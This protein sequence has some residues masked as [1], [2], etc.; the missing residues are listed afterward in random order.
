VFHSGAGY[1][2][3]DAKGGPKGG[4]D[5]YPGGYGPPGGEGGANAGTPAHG[6]TTHSAPD[7]HCYYYNARTGTSQ[8]ERP[9][10]MDS[11]QFNN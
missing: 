5:G 2:A 11:P 8:W 9:A 4:R 1:N 3:W 6:W 10:E 7:G